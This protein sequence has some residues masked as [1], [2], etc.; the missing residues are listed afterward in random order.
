[1]QADSIPLV[2]VTVPNPG[3][4]AAER[5]QQALAQAEARTIG[6]A[7]DYEAAA[8][9]LKAIKGKWS[10][11]DDSRKALKRPIDEA[12][13][14]V[15]AFFAQPLDFLA[16]AE[17]ILKRKMLDFQ[18]EQ[19]R[20]RREEQR[21]ADEAARR[22]R[23]RIEAQAAKASAAGRTE[24]A[25]VLETRAATV[26]APVIQREAP[27]VAGLSTRDVWRFEVTDEALVPREYLSVDERKIRGVVNSL[28]GSARIPGVRVYC[29]KSLAAGGA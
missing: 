24:R 21:K 16:R 19:D 2:A 26:V 25:A 27:K 9:E 8:I 28:K 29:E 13:K 15:Q 1:M 23:E 4:G 3:A 10:E 18:Q 11:I 5:A 17:S 7:V 12:A 14:R 20:L 22:E 6:C